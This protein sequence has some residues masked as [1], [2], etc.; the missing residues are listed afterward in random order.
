MRGLSLFP[1]VPSIEISRKQPQTENQ[2][3]GAHA[4]SVRALGRGRRLAVGVAAVGRRGG[5]RCGSELFALWRLFW[6]F[7][8]LC[9]PCSAC[10]AA[11]CYCATAG[12]D[13]ASNAIV[14]DVAPRRRFCL[15]LPTSQQ[16]A[17]ARG[18]LLSFLSLI[19]ALFLLHAIK[20]HQARSLQL[21]CP[22]CVV[23][24]LGGFAVGTQMRGISLLFLLVP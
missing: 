11:C 8:L 3:N 10:F 18:G 7:L 6:C 23:G 16:P 1:L 4:S 13:A 17:A 9:L 5:A 2:K 14:L 20:R 15:A 24:R 19:R 12:W 21:P 22:C